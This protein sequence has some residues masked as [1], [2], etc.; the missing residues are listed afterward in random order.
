MSILRK[1]DG[2]SFLCRKQHCSSLQVVWVSLERYI[3]NKLY[4]KAQ[5][6]SSLIKRTGLV[7]NKIVYG[8]IVSLLA[9][10]LSACGTSD[11]S[12]GAEVTAAI[13]TR[14]AEIVSE[15]LQAGQVINDAISGTMTA[16]AVDAA[17]AFTPTPELSST[18]QETLAPASPVVTVSE[19]TNCRSGPGTGFE[20]LGVMDIGESA[21]VVGHS[22]YNDNWLI[23]LPKNPAI[24]CWLWAQY[25]TVRG[26]VSNVPEIVPPATPT[27][28]SIV[29]SSSNS[30]QANLV[31]GLFFLNPGSPACGQ[32]FTVGIDVTNIG[33]KSTTA[34]GTVSLV[35]LLVAD[36]S[37]Q[38]NT[39]GG[40]PVLSPGQTYRV[41]MPLTL[42][43]EY[44]KTHRIKVTV[45]PSNIIPES[46][47]G[48]NTRTYEYTLLVGSCP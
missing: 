35:D 25:A 36:G 45:D 3:F 41:N 11:S 10:L 38:A 5:S 43:A 17:P 39:I 8:C 12:K 34:S 18:P 21:E 40:F 24:T 16:L 27:S 23:K 9:A 48:D 44:N 2:F 1:E 32:T 15:T 6:C 33:T 19:Q 28:Q 29:P 7:M 13:E 22:I 14:A 42:L 30:D 4:N 31:P 26:D 47:D 37:T 20:V 46:D